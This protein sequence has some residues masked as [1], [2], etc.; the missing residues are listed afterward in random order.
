MKTPLLPIS[1]LFAALALGACASPCP[2]E[3]SLSAFAR[4]SSVSAGGSDGGTEASL[5]AWFPVELSATVTVA[6]GGRG[7]FQSAAFS[8]GACTVERGST[9]D[10][11]S[12]EIRCGT[13]TA[14][15]CSA[16]SGYAHAPAGEEI[17]H[18]SLSWADR[19]NGV[20]GSAEY[21]WSVAPASGGGL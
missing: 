7:A 8:D 19:P 17:L 15:A 13:C 9:A 1:L 4:R 6:G 21:Q 5:M 3:G 11:C 18:G 2:T 16:L 20:P 12:L 14:G 10:R